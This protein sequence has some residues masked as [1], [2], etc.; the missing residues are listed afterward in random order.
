MKRI[1]VVI[2]F[3]I[4]ITGQVFAAPRNTNKPSDKIW[5][6]ILKKYVDEEGMVDYK[7]IIKDKDQLQVYLDMLSN[8]P[9]GDN[10]SK[11]EKEA[12]WINAYNAFT[13]KLII[14]H[15]PVKSI[16]D[17]GPKHQIPFVNTPWE[18]KFFKI[19][20]KHFKLDKIEHTIL[21]KKFDDPRIHFAVVCASH[22]C[23]RLRREAYEGDKLNEQLNEQAKDFLTDKRK[24]KITPEK[25]QLSSYFDWYKKDFK[26]NAGTVINYVN[27]YSPVK[28][29]SNANVSYLDY[30]WDLN[31]QK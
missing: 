22:S 6:E 25:P 12:Y 11:D 14:N 20:H 28:I 30:N 29:K 31:E 4:A 8:N 19:G 9:P 13:I 7:G 1:L 23:A 16:K 5:T 24:N 10:W 3:I 2:I 27:K 26:K 15:Y 18:K 21:R 17:I